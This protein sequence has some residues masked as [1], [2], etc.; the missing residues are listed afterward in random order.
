MRMLYVFMCSIYSSPLIEAYKFW[1]YF[2]FNFYV[3]SFFVIP[4]IT[5]IL[6][7][8]LLFDSHP[9]NLF[10]KKYSKSTHCQ[11][12]N[13]KTYSPPTPQ[14]TYYSTL[15]LLLHTSPTSRQF[16]FEAFHEFKHF[17]IKFI[18]STLIFPLMINFILKYHHDITTIHIF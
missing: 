3:V 11:N 2:I 10:L 6:F 14:F 17:T 4:S 7:L 16:F 12:W 18:F 1:S 8:F 13:L 5:K 9:Q 15:H